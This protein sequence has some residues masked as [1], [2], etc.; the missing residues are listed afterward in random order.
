MVSVIETYDM[1]CLIEPGGDLNLLAQ[2]GHMTRVYH[3]LFYFII[4]D[5]ANFL[6]TNFKSR[7]LQCLYHSGSKLL[8]DAM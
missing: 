7:I 6:P 4:A 3:I 1:H 2:K 8:I 5:F